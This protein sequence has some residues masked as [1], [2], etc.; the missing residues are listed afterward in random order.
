MKNIFK[1]IIIIFFF[2]SLIGCTDELDNDPIGLLTID[3]VVSDPSITTIEASVKSSYEPLKNTLNGIIPGWRWDLG[4]VFRND[5]VLQDIASNDMN[6]KWSPDGDQP[7]MDEVG[8][9]TFTSE[10]Q[11]FNGIW[12][13]DYEGI[14]RVNIAIN[15]LL[16]D[17]IIQKIGMS[18]DRR[19]QLLSESY[20]LRAFYYFDLVNNFGDVPLVLSS[21]VSFE[22]ALSV[23]VRESVDIVKA[24]INSDLAAAK[25]LAPIEKYPDPAEPWR[26]S[27][28]AIIALQAKLALFDADWS[29]VISLILELDLP[30]NYS[31]N[32][33]YFDSFD[34]NLEFT[35]NEVIFA[36]DH[37][38]NEIPNN[39]NG[40][41]SVVGWGFF[42]PTDDF[43]AAFEANDPRLLYTTTADITDKF[44]PKIIGSKTDVID[45]GNKVYIRYAD[46][47]L[48]KAEAMNESGDYPGAIAAINEIR[49][50]AR[51]TVTIDGS[52]VPAGTL[53]DRGSSTNQPEI[54]GW[55][56]SERRVE[57]GFESH[58][59]N[60]LKRWGTAQS[61]L[62]ALGVNFQDHNNLYPIP[63]RDIDKSGGSITQNSGY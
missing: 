36:Y 9:F 6:K 2:T 61:V 3:Q 16:D 38:S 55:I 62:S 21:P 40:L 53:P 29:M 50:R 39:T 22:E 44:S 59:F 37:R 8:A 17:E 18:Q 32:A 4:T 11:A 43:I 25:L 28:G 33:N 5:I 49:T 54:M 15:L 27:K 31:L 1:N 45:N 47:L 46:V 35:D 63:Q 60:D 20:F 34:N 41:K 26:A 12:V 52:T 10:N 23:S 51:T 30:G 56:M 13:Y 57:L 7:W 48:W 14:S 42:A 58:R 24:Q 19:D